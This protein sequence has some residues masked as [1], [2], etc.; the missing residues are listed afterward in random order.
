MT[1][2]HSLLIV[3]PNSNLAPTE[4][5]LKSLFK[6]LRVPDDSGWIGQVKTIAGHAVAIYN[7]IF[8]M[9]VM[10]GKMPI[11]TATEI[12][13]FLKDIHKNPYIVY[14]IQRLYQ[15]DLPRMM[16]EALFVSPDD[17]RLRNFRCSDDCF[18]T[19]VVYARH[20]AASNYFLRFAEFHEKLLDEKRSE[21]LRLLI[22]LGAKKISLIDKNQQGKSGSTSAR[23]DDPTSIADVNTEVKMEHAVFSDLKIDGE[24]DLPK[25]PPIVP[26]DLKWLKKE[27]SWQTIVHG[28]L[29]GNRMK[30]YKVRFTYTQNF[31]ITSDVAA[32]LEGFGVSIG[33]NFSNVKITEQ[34]YCVEFY[35]SDDYEK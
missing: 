25:N 22:S 23:I 3:T 32:K 14:V 28:R 4:E 15:L 16:P 27:S 31:G 7:P 1:S 26:D 8:L 34:E 35:S 13:N 2:D 6:E 20:P 29:N 9:N 5:T 17:E 18:L 30:T 19:N 12:N 10:R 24:F 33:G 11:P 21:F